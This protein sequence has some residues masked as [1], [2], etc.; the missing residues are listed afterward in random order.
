M[1]TSNKPAWINSPGPFE[2]GQDVATRTELFQELEGAPLAEV[3]TWLV[4]LNDHVMLCKD[5]TM[6]AALRVG[7]L[8]RD[9]TSVSEMDAL[10]EQL[11]Y[12]AQRL[13]NETPILGW[14]V[15]RRRTTVYPKGVFP[16]PV[17]QHM[18][19]L[20]HQDFLKKVQ[21]INEHVVTFAL[22]AAG[23]G[24]KLMEHIAREQDRGSGAMGVISALTT[25]AKSTLGSN[26]FPY[27]SPV[28]LEPDLERFEKALD[29]FISASKTLKLH[30]LTADELGGFLRRSTSVVLDLD[31]RCPLPLPVY[32]GDEVLPV[33][34]VDNSYSDVLVFEHNGKRQFAQCLSIDLRLLKGPLTMMLLDGLMG[35]PCEFT[36]AHIFVTLNKRRGAGEARAFSAYH[37]ARKYNWKQILAAA[38]GRGELDERQ[39]KKS[40]ANASDEAEEIKELVE[41]GQEVLGDYYGVVMVHADDMDPL[42]EATRSVNE[43]LN[44]AQLNPRLEGLHKFSSFCATIPGSHAQVARWQKITQENFIDLC[45]SRTVGDGA[46]VNR[47]LSQKL[48]AQCEALIAFSTL[49]GTVF[50]YTGY[51]GQL[52]HELLL[53]PSRTG[54]TVIGILEWTQFRKYPGARV[55][56]FDKDYSCRPAIYLQG[57]RY[58]D[59]TPEKATG[60]CLSPIAALMKSG[61]LTHLAFVVSWIEMLPQARGYQPTAKD[62]QEIERAVRSTATAGARDP[63]LLRL[64]QVVARLPQDTELAQALNMWVGDAAY[65]RYFDNPRDDFDV[66]HLVGVEMGSVLTHAELA[67]PLMAYAFYRVEA[68]LRRLGGNDT[69]VPTLI[70]VPECWFFLA[71]P[72]F[73]ARLENWLATLAKLGARVVFDT[74]TPEKLTQ[75]PAFP[76]FRD[77]VPSVIYTPNGKAR[78]GSLRELYTREWGLTD[79]DL[80]A[81]VNGVPQQDYFIVTGG[82]KRRVSF[83]LSNELLAHVTS[84]TLAQTT[85][86]Y[87]IDQ[88]LP[89]GWQQQ[90]VERLVAAMKERKKSK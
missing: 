43:I 9:S 54:K 15:R 25:A 61:D 47:D 62:R 4:P 11:L 58:I 29:A 10:R 68:T 90:Y 74:Q 28:E 8:D 53:G 19:H 1:T 73:T 35:V 87:F 85:L 41:E 75:S 69:P 34:N 55:L 37:A 45:P 40:R 31:T 51:V 88:G 72:V 7:G 59:F 21:Y 20:M 16:D 36:M 63:S 67:G 52:G 3:I 27:E 39:A 89:A 2:P 60:H 14:H 46:L 80:P 66:D 44:T 26:P 38:A 5:G 24:A 22:P 33:G 64:G 77:N 42:R 57:G 70:Y 81:I 56:V 83:G 84:D 48:G 65:G 6:L 17:S 13:G 23:S 18:D 79:E 76:V 49:A 78:D 50:Y 32:F 82:I 30:L 86:Q 71:N 12:T